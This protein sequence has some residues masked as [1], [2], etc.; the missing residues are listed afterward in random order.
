MSTMWQ[1]VIKAQV[2][3]GGKSWNGSSYQSTT[4][5]QIVTVKVPDTGGYFATKALLEGAYGSG[6]VL[7][8]TLCS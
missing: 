8:L 2:P 6:S 4:V 3:S 5:G 7:S 1:A